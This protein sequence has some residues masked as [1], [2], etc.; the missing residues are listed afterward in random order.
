MK[1]SLFILCFIAFVWQGCASNTPFQGGTELGNPLRAVVGEATETVAS[2]IPFISSAHAATCLATSVVATNSLGETTEALLDANCQFSLEL[3]TGQAYQLTLYDGADELATFVFEA[4][5]N[6][7]ITTFIL[8]EGSNDIDLGNTSISNGIA[9]SEANP[10]E[11]NDQDGDGTFDYDDDDDDD[12]GIEDDEDE[13]DCDD[14]DFI[15]S[16]DDDDAECDFDE[17]DETDETDEV[18]E[19]DEEE[20]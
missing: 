19:T 6:V 10:Y 13:E 12:D 9:L 2:L 3:E 11:Q 20:F 7:E 4:R 5:P 8:S 14:D 16:F 1:K 18:D 15:N 17:E